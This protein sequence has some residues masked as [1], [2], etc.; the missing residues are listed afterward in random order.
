MAINMTAM[1]LLHLNITRIAHLGGSDATAL[2]EVLNC[3]PTN[4]TSLTL[5]DKN[6]ELQD[7]IL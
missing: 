7:Y 6:P 1:W 4:C 5:H 2:A 3:V